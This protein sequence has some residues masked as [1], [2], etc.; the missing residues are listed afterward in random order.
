MS[1]S[2][3]SFQGQVVIVTGSS[4]GIGQACAIHFGSLGAHVIVNYH[5]NKEEALDTLDQIKKKG[6][7]GIVVQADVSKEKDVMLLF[8]K[9]IE[10]FGR[11]DVMVSNAGLQVD[12]KFLDMTLKQ[13]QKVID[14]NL[15]GQ[16]ICTREAAR[17]FVKQAKADSKDT[18]QKSIGKI[19][20]MSSVH[21]IIPWAGHVNYAA[22][23][24]GI[25]ML[26]RSISQELA[27]HKIRINSVSPGAIRTTI[28]KSVWSDDAK[29]EELMQLIPYRRIGTPEDVAKAVAWLAS[30]D[31][32]YVNGETLYIDGGMTL[33]PEF[34][35]NG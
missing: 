11:L 29:M 5:S 26:M 14:V 15:T 34:A 13:W 17:Q 2:A 8:E 31:S 7:D 9:T 19:V 27:P 21:D 30:D 16:F 28:N 1:H 33:Y 23:K 20:M 35:D 3:K 10:K 24:G 18:P 22:S 25:M 32:D 4:S 12:A 6:G